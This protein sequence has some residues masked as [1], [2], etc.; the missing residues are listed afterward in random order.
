MEA[1]TLGLGLV[2][3]IFLFNKNINRILSTIFKLL[4]FINL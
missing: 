2:L 4:L 3:L 1:I